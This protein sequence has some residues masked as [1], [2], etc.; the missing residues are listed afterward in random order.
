[1]P[2][3]L[4]TLNAVLNASASAFLVAG[5][6]F[7]RRRQR[8]RHRLCMLT[9]FA[10]SVAFLIGYVV[11]HIQVGNVPFQGHGWARPVYFAILIPHIVLAATVVPLALVTLVRALR[12]RFDKHKKIA[13]WTLPVWLY[14]SAS[15]VV[16]YFMLYHW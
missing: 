7:I 5:W 8:E 14:V 2:S 6:L 15:G 1:M 4:A 12:N 13:R 3:P 10:L 11:H 9:A 16:V